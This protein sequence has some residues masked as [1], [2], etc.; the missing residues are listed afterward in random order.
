M[1]TINLHYIAFIL[2]FAFSGREQVVFI[3][4]TTLIVWASVILSDTTSILLVKQS[5]YHLIHQ[6]QSPCAFTLSFIACK[7]RDLTHK[8]IFTNQ[9]GSSRGSISTSFTATCC[10]W[11]SA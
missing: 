9:I 11:L 10:G 6:K 4:P 3:K 5:L 7:Y 1:G 8:I 2:N